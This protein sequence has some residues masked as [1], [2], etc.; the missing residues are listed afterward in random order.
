MPF[1]TIRFEISSSPVLAVIVTQLVMSVPA[2]VMKI[3]EPLIIHL[4]SRSSAVVREAAASDPAPGSVRPNAA[5]LRPDARS[6]SHCR[7]CSSFPNSRIG[8]VPSEVCAASVIATDESIRVSSSTAIAYESVSAP[9][10]P[11]S[12]GTGIPISPSAASSATR[13]YGNRCSLSSSA[14]TGATRS[15]ANERTV[16][17]TSS[18][19]GPS[20]TISR[21]PYPVPPR[22]VR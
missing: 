17:R 14:A 7:F 1:G 21:T 15:S 18:C 5:S 13:S 8:I 3:F 4:P 11:Y 20:S 16:P 22:C 12:S 6:G 2:L 10:P 9:A 19:S